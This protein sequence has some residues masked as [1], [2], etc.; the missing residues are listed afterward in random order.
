MINSRPWMVFQSFAC[1][2]NGSQCLPVLCCAI[3]LSHGWMRQR[4]TTEA[5]ASSIMYYILLVHSL[6]LCYPVS[7]SPNTPDCCL[8]LPLQTDRQILQPEILT[9]PSGSPLILPITAFT[10]LSR[11]TPTI[12]PDPDRSTYA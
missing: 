1:P 3:V 5:V 4:A 12:G 2:H 8:S 6:P 7:V 11:L 9:V 10:A